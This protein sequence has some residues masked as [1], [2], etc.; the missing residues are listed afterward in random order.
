MN[1][2]MQTLD[3]LKAALGSPSA[4]LAKTISTA[5]GLVPFDLQAP[6][7]NLYPVNT[8]I[9]NR[10]PRVGGG[11]GTATNWKQITSVTGSGY[12]A[13]A[14]VPEGQRTARMSYSAVNKSASYVTLGEEDNV[15]FEAIS[16]GQGFED[17]RST[18]TMRVLQKMMLK[19]E[20][21]LIFGNNSLAL[22]TP[23]TPT[24]SAGGSGGT[25]GAATYSVMVVALTG[26][27]FRNSSLSGGVATSQ[28]VT[29]ADGATYTLKGGSSNKSAAA[30]QAITLGQVLSCSVAPVTGAVGYAWYVGTAGSEKLERITTINSA[31]FNAPLVGGTRQAA[32]VIT[33][34]NSQN[35]LAFDGLM[36]HAFSGTGAYVRTLATGTA[37]TGT[38]LTSSGRGTINEIDDMLQAMWDTNQVSPD[39]IYVSS[40]ELKN[41]TNKAL[42]GP[43]TSPLLQVFTPPEQGY[44]G[45]MAGGV[46]GFYFNPFAMNGGIRIP[47]MLHPSLPA[48]TILAWADNLPAQYQSN[49]VPRC[50]EVKV[51]RDYYQLDFPI[52][53]RA[54]E[55]GVY[56]EEVLA[57]YAPFAIGVITNIANG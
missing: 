36:T 21:A 7:K 27:G 50:A 53:T 13:M 15:T 43:G 10:L 3:L 11:Q 40:Q 8:P 25:L 29:G 16:A 37:G 17:V 45:L 46:I 18:G 22:G 42:A 4:E 1:P 41:I 44:P 28:T 55:F 57:V 5:T 19:E 30:T 12:D 31:T 47:I 52:R 24:L 38:V 20:N 32:T 48:G 14:W 35:T 2:T 23:G 56:A 54:Q 9:R 6:A 33:A 39:V 26:E 49:N 34:D 51:R